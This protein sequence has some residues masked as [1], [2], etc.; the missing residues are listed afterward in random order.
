M[1]VRIWPGPSA[2]DHDAIRQKDGLL[3]QMRN[4]HHAL[5]RKRQLASAGPE[6]INLAAQTF[7][8]ENIQGA[9]RLIHAKQ[10]RPAR[11][12]RAMPTPLLHSARQFLGIS[13]LEP[14]KPDHVDA[15]GDA[16]LAGCRIKFKAVQCHADVV[17]NRQPWKQGEILEDQRYARMNS[18]QAAFRGRGPFRW[19]AMRSPIIARRSVLFPQPLGPRI[20]STS[21][22]L[23]ARETLLRTRRL[24]EVSLFSKETVTSMASE[25]VATVFVPLPFPLIPRSD[26]QTVARFRQPVQPFPDNPIKKNDKQRHHDNRSGKERIFFSV[27]SLVNDR[28]KTKRDVIG[29]T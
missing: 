16:I 10:L 25:M 26:I 8:G 18:H 13:V 9:E 12:A 2:H 22:G 21:P 15:A 23:I 28:P 14:F 6:S 27:R 7:G 24:E 29:R 4:H 17:A 11:S 1:I 5:E 20:A 3:D 19:W